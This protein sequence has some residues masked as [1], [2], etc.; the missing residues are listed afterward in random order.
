MYLHKHIDFENITLNSIN[1]A[2]HYYSYGVHCDTTMLRWIKS[3]HFKNDWV[4]QIQNFWLRNIKLPGKL[5]SSK[6]TLFSPRFASDILFNHHF[7]K[8][9]KKYSKWSLLRQIDQN[10]SLKRFMEKYSYTWKFLETIQ[11]KVSIQYLWEEK[12]LCTE[13]KINILKNQNIY[14]S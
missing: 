14:T 2:F 7:W 5:R 4:N 10:Y 3:S 6:K 12:L 1:N 13:K 9:K 8:K 11:R